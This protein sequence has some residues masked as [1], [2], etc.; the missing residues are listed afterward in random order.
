[1]INEIFKKRKSINTFL[2]L[3]IIF[4]SCSRTEKQASGIYIK[5]P[6]LYTID[7]LFLLMDTLNATTNSQN[8]FSSY[9]YKQR[10]YDKNSGELLYENESAW[11]LN[12]DGRLELDNL[13]LD[14]D[15]NPEKL[16]YSQES[17]KNSLIMASLPFKGSKII[18][19]DDDRFF[20]VKIN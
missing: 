14:M 13:F 2:F 4:I 20:Y 11:R 15:S 7:S 1:M 18:L 6:S 5:S 8:S 3:V 17:M 12:N 19:N 9:K 10:V 16:S